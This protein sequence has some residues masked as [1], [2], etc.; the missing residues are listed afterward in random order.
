MLKRFAI[1]VAVLTAS[2]CAV[3]DNSF[4]PRV[5]TLNFGIDR[6]TNDAILTNIVRASRL[7]PLTFVAISKISGSQ[8][9]SLSN[10][11]PTFAFGPDLTSAQKQFTFARMRL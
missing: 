2:G 9:A 4:S 3:I 11:L 7:Q 1:S 8:T 6:A 5:S 10:G